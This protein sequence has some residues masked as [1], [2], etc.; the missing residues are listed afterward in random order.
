VTIVDSI[1]AVHARLV[2]N[3]RIRLTLVSALVVSYSAF[4]VTIL[5]TIARPLGW[6]VGVVL[7]CVASYRGYRKGLFTSPT[8]EDASAIIDQRFDTKD[9]ALTL[10]ATWDEAGEAEKELLTRQLQE[11]VPEFDVN[12]AFPLTLETGLKRALATLPLV[13]GLLWYL[14]DDRGGAT[15]ERQAA[16]VSELLEQRAD[17]PLPVRESLMEL[18]NTLE[19]KPL[20]DQAVLEALQAAQ[21]EIDQAN[22]SLD[23]GAEDSTDETVDE[24]ETADGDSGGEIAED[25]P[26][27]VAPV[28]SKPTPTPEPSPTPPAG[29]TAPPPNQSKNEEQ[30][31]E[32]KKDPAEQKQK[33]EQESGSSNDTD[34]QN[35]NST[36]QQSGSEKQPSQSK[37]DGGEGGSKSE[38]QQSGNQQGESQGQQGQEGSEEGQEGDGDGN[39]SSK[40]GNKPGKSGGQSGS[41]GQS[42]QQGQQQG[43]GEGKPDQG[44]EKKSGAK[45]DRAG[46]K[47]STGQDTGLEQA[48][49][50]LNKI[51]QELKA[52]QQGDEKGDQEGEKE[53]G[54]KGDKGESDSGKPSGAGGKKQGQ[55]EK[56]QGAGQGQQG[57]KD[58]GESKQDKKESGGKSGGKDG[59]GGKPSDTRPESGSEGDNE[60]KEEF[61]EAPKLPVGSSLPKESDAAMGPGDENGGL[62]QGLGDRK[63]FKDTEIKTGDEKYDTRF[64]GKDGKVGL[65][66][67]PAR[68]KTNLEDV[69]LAKPDPVKDPTEQPIPLEYRDILE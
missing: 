22:E 11:I 26:D 66:K 62:G 65:N 25:S 68:S 17:I 21:A 14:G 24:S 32:K 63:G 16:I 36:D 59:Q 33:E 44:G 28:G 27:N 55:G 6:L 38:Q 54:E 2:R 8:I 48:Q 47:T 42:G 34:V 50:A 41:Q 31:E 56:K 49:E 39:S 12:A 61:G 46:D 35:S 52:Q 40:Q 45:G 23:G 20:T 18:K 15:A 30:H 57:N 19:T 13:W 43:S 3:K 69:K 1:N 29:A 4:I 67:S 9:R 51:E 37:N 10:A 5:S 58:Q 60:P 53:G 64:T 7:L